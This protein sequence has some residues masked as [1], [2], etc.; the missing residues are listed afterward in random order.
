MTNCRQSPKEQDV[1]SG[2][3]VGIDE[4]AMIVGDS[5]SGTASGKS[6]ASTPMTS[7]QSLL[8]QRHGS[9]PWRVIVGGEKRSILYDRLLTCELTERS[10]ERMDE[11]RTSNAPWDP[12]LPS[13][14]VMCAFLGYNFRRNMQDALTPLPMAWS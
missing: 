10:R 13:I 7:F 11:R 6:T 2:V 3:Y 5:G 8:L 14:R 1:F 4:G 9:C 12:K